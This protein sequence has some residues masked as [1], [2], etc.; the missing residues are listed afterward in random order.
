MGILNKRHSA[1]KPK[2]FSQ[3]ITLSSTRTILL[4]LAICAVIVACGSFFTSTQIMTNSLMGKTK[5]G[6]IHLQWILQSYKN[7]VTSL[8]TMPE[9]SDENLSPQEKMHLLTERTQA[10]GFITAGILDKT[11]TG[12]A[13]GISHSDKPYFAEAYGG[14]VSIAGPVISRSDNKSKVIVCAG[15]VWK[16]GIPGSTVDGIVFCSINPEVLER[17]VQFMNFQK[18]GKAYIIDQNKNIVVSWKVD[19]RF[20]N[21]SKKIQ[22]VEETFLFSEREVFR[23]H[24]KGLMN[25]FVGAHIGN[26]P[27]WT[28]ILT[29][30]VTDSMSNFMVTLLSI[31]IFGLS[32]LF[33]ARFVMASNA[34][35]I[36]KPVK[37]LAER[38]R[39]AS[40]G[41]FSSDIPVDGSLEEISVISEATQR[42]INRISSILAGSNASTDFSNIFSLFDINEYED[43]CSAFEDSFN[44]SL[45]IYDKNMKKKLGSECDDSMNGITQNIYINGRLA[46]KFI[47]SPRHNCSLRHE[48]LEAIVLNLSLLLGKILQ[49]IVNR[50]ERY[51]VWQQNEMINVNNILSRTENISQEIKKWL[52]MAKRNASHDTRLD[53]ISISSEAEKQISLIN[54]STEYARFTSLN[55]EIHEEDYNSRSLIENISSKTK[56]ETPGRHQIHINVDPELPVMLFGD[57]DSIER[58]I[59]RSLISLQNFNS[60]SDISVSFNYEKKGLGLNLL[61]RIIIQTPSLTQNEIERLKLFVMKSDHT[62]ETL[63]VFEQKILTA[64]KLVYN[65][66][67]HVEVSL[68]HEDSDMTVTI[69]IPQLDA[70]K[71]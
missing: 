56:H 53:W 65:M 48:E 4:A 8:G 38:L 44:I 62:G 45:C 63:T 67:G 9:F 33:S 54:E 68:P 41:D 52:D 61:V 5:D 50:E 46:G 34:Q 6:A 13:D 7:V 11:G 15:P 20:R 36:S 49:N 64:V 31:L 32:L 14:R 70:T 22:K 51:Q 37:E 47:I 43:I 18:N 27:G 40:V 60:D 24:I 3:V 23:I 55:A 59:T 28:L 66:N 69:S 25:G 71:A 12:I 17:T 2:T 57:K 29:S 58:S 10:F 39:H 19:E 16:D 1:S 21:S 35:R 30:P 42:L 26:T